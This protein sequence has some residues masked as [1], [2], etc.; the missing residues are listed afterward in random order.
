[1]KSVIAIPLGIAYS[2]S[3][4]TLELSTGPK[5]ASAPPKSSFDR[6]IFRHMSLMKGSRYFVVREQIK[7][8]IAFS[9]KSH[10]TQGP[11]SVA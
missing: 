2:A 7:K 8:T 5:S 3:A 4:Q 11:F 1:M 6:S 10:G 9:S